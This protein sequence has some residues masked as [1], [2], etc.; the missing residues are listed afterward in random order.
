MAVRTNEEMG[1][2]VAALKRFRELLMQQRSKFENYLMVLD[3]ERAD[4]ES[5]DV[6]RLAA[7]V[8]FEEAIVSEIFTFQKVIDPLEQ[9]YRAAYPAAAEDPELPALR[10]TLDD[11]KDEVLRRN[12]ENRALLKSKMEL[13]RAELAGFRN[14]LA[15]RASVYARQGEAALLDI[16]G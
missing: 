14:P 9:I 7:H 4:I 2:R 3:H 15:A 8:E 1:Q 11:L 5:G 12:A 16:S 10:G 6:D 13:V